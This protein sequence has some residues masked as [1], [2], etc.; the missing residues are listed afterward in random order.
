MIITRTPYRI[1]FFGG[2]T[3]YPA[4][5][6]RHGGCVLSTS[7]DK[8]CYITCRYLP[9]FFSNRHRVVWS[10]IEA[11]NSIREILHP[12]VREGLRLLGFS[13]LIGVEVHHQGDLPARTGI[14][15]SSSFAVGIILGLMALRG[16]RISRHA[17]ALKAIELEQEALK[18]PVGSQDQVAAAHGGCN[19]IEFL[20][21]GDIK[22]RPV[23]ASAARLALL[24]QHL[25]LFYTGT[26]R[27]GAEVAADVVA[28]I[29]SR[30]QQLLR[31]AQLVDRAEKTLAGGSLDD[32]GLMLDETW[33]LKR[34]LSAH[35]SNDSVEAIYRRAIGAGALGG[36]LLGAGASG[37]MLFYV[38]IDRQT[39]VRG[40]L[41]DLLHVPFRFDQEGATLLT[42]ITPVDA[43]PQVAIC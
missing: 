6:R 42:P 17:L 38:P 43:I 26:S 5:Y 36:K 16:E 31:M 22:V 8:Y 34:Q 4:W 40:A 19:I 2:G 35:I 1:S 33:K 13:D 23:A 11:V 10:H 28:N 30:E 18:D 9:P 41:R 25:M 24:E 14:G 32:F 37:F 29:T 20:P 21:S 39:T 7:I 12:A 3:D 15:S 27:L